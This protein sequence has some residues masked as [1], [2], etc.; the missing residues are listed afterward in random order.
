MAFSLLKFAARTAMGMAWQFVGV[1]W[2]G[3]L[4]WGGKETVAAAVSNS[5][6]PH[7]GASPADLFFVGEA[8]IKN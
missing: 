8:R 2:H 4:F 7:Q 1:A 6:P 3:N 5:M